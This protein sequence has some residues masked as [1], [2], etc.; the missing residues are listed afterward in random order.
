MTEVVPPT[1]LKRSL[2]FIKNRLW[3]QLSSHRIS[4]RCL[5]PCK[6]LCVILLC[7]F[8]CHR[9]AALYMAQK[10]WKLAPIVDIPRICPP[11]SYP[12]LSDQQMQNNETT[13]PSVCLTTLTDKGRSNKN[14]SIRTSIRTSTT[15]THS[16]PKKRR[17]VDTLFSWRNYH[18]IL[19]LTWDNKQR[20]ATTHGYHLF[21]QSHLLDTT[22]QSSWSKIPAV[23]D[24]LQ[25]QN[26][27]T[28]DNN[29]DSSRHRP[30]C[31]WVLWLDADT[32]FMNSHKS[33]NDILP[34]NP[35]IHL[36]VSHDNGGSQT[37]NA[38]VWMVRNNRWTINFLHQWYQ[39]WYLVLPSGTSNH[40]DNDALNSILQ[41]LQ[42]NGDFDKHVGVPPRCTFNSFGKFLTPNQYE[43]LVQ[44]SNLAEKQDWFLSEAYYH[45]GDLLAHVAGVD[46]KASTLQS[47]LDKAE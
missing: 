43:K 41:Q 22:R 39:T 29:N 45:K 5:F 7:T 3:N 35:N 23:I 37:Y 28:T 32:V 11:P 10:E 31:D 24:L 8:T 20:Y 1:Q 21:D 44:N 14:N 17:W 33:L 27:P 42:T 36:L 47:L 9:W 16:T 46:N 19:D 12:T 18:G 34:S 2:I 25:Q 38:G 30:L 40:G 4:S 13:R 26:E 6:G 15:Q